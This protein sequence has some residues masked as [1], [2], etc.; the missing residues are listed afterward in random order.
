MGNEP[1]NLLELLALAI[2]ADNVE[3]LD[4]VIPR[5]VWDGLFDRDL[6]R[7]GRDH[8]GEGYTHVPPHGEG[9]LRDCVREL[10]DDTHVFELVNGEWSIK[11]PVACR[12]NL[13]G[14]P[15]HM[16]VQAQKSFGPPIPEG[17]FRVDVVDG[18]VLKFTAVEENL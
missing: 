6:I 12:P 18:D 2:V 15:V 17:R 10:V 5:A 1:L 3:L 14:C 7:T 9:A 4:D 8:T 13:L 16:L 11:H